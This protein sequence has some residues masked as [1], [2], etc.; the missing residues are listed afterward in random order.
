[1]FR[2]Y[3]CDSVPKISDINSFP[4]TNM[5]KLLL[6]RYQTYSKVDI[7]IIKLNENMNDLHYDTQILPRNECVINTQILHNMPPGTISLD[8]NSP[9]HVCGRNSIV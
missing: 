9:L 5:M 2:L 6:V 1:M 8:I 7:S 3:Y 4:S